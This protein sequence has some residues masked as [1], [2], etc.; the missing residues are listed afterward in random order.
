MLFQNIPLPS[1]FLDIRLLGAQGCICRSRGCASRGPSCAPHPLPPPHEGTLCPG[2][3]GTADP[4]GAQPLIRTRARNGL[5]SA[6]AVSASPSF[7]SGSL[8][9]WSLRPSYHTG[10]TQLV[11]MQRGDDALQECHRVV[12]SLLSRRSAH[13][14]GWTRGC[15]RGKPTNKLPGRAA[16]R[17]RILRRRLQ[18]ALR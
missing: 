8:G 6:S 10:Q 13:A 16:Q 15:S 17:A 14:T 11:M 3:L 18:L 4:R 5:C 12:S 7:I 9:C 1:G 2:C